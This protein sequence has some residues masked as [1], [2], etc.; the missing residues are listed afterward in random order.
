MGEEI[1]YQLN[2]LLPV[3]QLRDFIIRDELP[4]GLSCAEALP[5]NLNASPYDTA[6][7]LPGGT[8]RP[9]CSGGVV[10]WQFGSQRVTKGTVDNVYD[11]EISFLARVDNTAGTNEA[12]VLSNGDPATEATATYRDE[13]GNL[14]TLDFG[15]VDVVVREPDI[16]LTKSF[17][18]TEA[19]AADVLTV[20]VTAENT[21]TATA[22]N[23]RVLEDLTGT[24]L[25]YEGNVGGTN[26]PDSIDTTTLGPNQPIFSWSAP[27]GID[28]G[29][30]HQL[31]L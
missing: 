17:A 20:T 1:R 22:Y 8:I 24:N 25:T 5:V 9:T 12:G 18:V 7:F 28:C 21:G 19:D 4:P 26:P 2:T 3:A 6:G 14:M 16:A 10:E 27:N 11:F 29:R 30:Q 13:L 23:L 31:H 15:Q